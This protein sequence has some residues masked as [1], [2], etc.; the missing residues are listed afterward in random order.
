VNAF[1]SICCDTITGVPNLEPLGRDNAMVAVCNDCSTA[2]PTTRL[3][4]ERGY[5]IHEGASLAKINAAADRVRDEHP[6]LGGRNFDRNET[7]RTKTFGWLLVR[8]PRRDVNGMPRDLA[9]ALRTLTNQ[10]WVREARFLGMTKSFVLFERPDPEL[11]AESRGASFN[12]I[13]WL[14]VHGERAS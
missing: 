9:T 6:R 3:G 5:E 10:P 2:K 13:A 14:E 12:P 1:C 4:P 7:M 8:V 11:A